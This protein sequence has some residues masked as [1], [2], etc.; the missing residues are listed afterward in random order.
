[1]GSGGAAP[2][3]GPGEERQREEVEVGLLP[4]V[5]SV[6][7]ASPAADA[8]QASSGL[9]F[10]FGRAFLCRHLSREEEEEEGPAGLIWPR[11]G[12]HWPCRSCASFRAG[13]CPTRSPVF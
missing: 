11:V 3:G 4:A 5:P 12:F 2:P 8:A 13:A 10:T 9:L 1:M 7:G 6:A